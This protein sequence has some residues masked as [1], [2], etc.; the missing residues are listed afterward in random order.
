MVDAVPLPTP[1]P[2][3][4]DMP[5]GTFSL[6]FNVN[7]AP[8]MCFNDTTQ[9]QAWSCNVFSVG[10]SGIKIARARHPSP[11]HQYEVTMTCNETYLLS[12]K[13]YIYGQ[14]PPCIKETALLTLV[15][16]ALEPN[17]G[18][19]WWFQRAY[20]KTIVLPESLFNAP[21]ASPVA[22][23]DRF[24][25]PGFGDGPGPGGFKRKGV[26]NPGDRPWICEW[27]GTVFEMFIYAQQNTSMSQR[28]GGPGGGSANS[29][30]RTQ[31]TTVTSTTTTSSSTTPTAT[32]A[33]VIVLADGSTTT[34]PPPPPSSTASREWPRPS[35]FGPDPDWKF[36]PP[37][38]AYPRVMKFEDRRFSGPPSQPPVCRQF[39]IGEGGDL[40][41]VLDAEGNP[42]EV[43]I[44]ES[45]SKRLGERSLVAGQSDPASFESYIAS[46]FGIRNAA[47]DLSD[48]GC[49][50]FIT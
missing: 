12:N 10:Q 30:T 16:D 42:I 45:E 22:R 7:R 47:S 36:D 49:L 48:C 41:P 40:R 1:P 24:G 17:R 29:A 35:D 32:I 2:D 39:Q 25:P 27:P 14:Q 19:A 4:P 8:N 37:P 13:M 20:N 44:V 23:R 3:L 18:P 34:V 31:S 28:G 46:Q 21:T 5:V 38:P 33:S 26:A 6:P 43:W 11:T 15:N 9:A 50:W